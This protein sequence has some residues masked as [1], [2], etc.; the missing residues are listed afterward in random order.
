MPWNDNR[1]VMTS[2]GVTV[3]YADGPVREYG[4]PGIP[5]GPKLGEMLAWYP[6][7]FAKFTLPNMRKET[8][9]FSFP[10]TGLPWLSDTDT[11]LSSINL[12]YFTEQKFSKITKIT[13]FHDGKLLDTWDQLDLWGMHDFSTDPAGPNTTDF[14]L[15]NPVN[16]G[17][18][19][20]GLCLQIEVE[21]QDVNDA[22]TFQRSITF[23]SATCTVEHDHRIANN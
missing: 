3:K 11:H 10:L 5:Q 7:T 22:E 12:Y 17:A 1:T 18:L 19:S 15:S 4:G 13:L 8:K 16:N 6:A 20:G 21:F 14:K 23:F 2:H 9:M